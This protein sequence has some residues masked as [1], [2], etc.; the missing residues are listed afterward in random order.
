MIIPNIWEKNGNQTTNQIKMEPPP[1][2]VVLNF[3]IIWLSSS[4]GKDWDDFIHNHRVWN[5]GRCSSK[6][7]VLKG[8][9]MV[10]MIMMTMM[11]MMMVVVMMVVMMMI[12]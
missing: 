8:N 3:D 12:N 10:L 5:W 6:I 9:M 11:M 7:T 1:F 4:M 2:F